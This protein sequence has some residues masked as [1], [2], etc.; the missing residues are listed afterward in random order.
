MARPP[1]SSRD[2]RNQ[3]PVAVTLSER[4]RESAL[5]NPAAIAL[6]EVSGVAISYRA[7]QKRIDD[8]TGELSALGI[9]ENDRVGLQ[10]PKSADAVAAIFALW[11]L[12]A[13]Y[14]PI[15]A[16]APAARALYAL[17]NCNTRAVIGSSKGNDRLR[18]ADAGLGPGQ[19]V[20]TQ[21]LII[22]FFDPVPGI[23]PEKHYPENLACILYTSGSTGYP[24]GVMLT[25]SNLASFVDWAISRFTL[26]PGEV[27]SSLAPLHFDLSVFD[28]FAGLGSGATVALFS[29]AVGRNPQLLADKLAG[30]RVTGVY[31]TPTL[32]QL[33]LRY[34]KLTALDYA[35][36]VRLLYAGEPFPPTALNELRRLWPDA[37][38]FNLYGPTETNVVTAYRVERGFS[39]NAIPIGTDCPYAET[40]LFSAGFL[41]HEP[42]AE[43]ELW[44]SGPS[45]AAGYVGEDTGNAFVES[46]G[47]RWYKTGD[48]VRVDEQ[49]NYVFLGRSD[50][51]I[52]RNGYRIEPAE[53]E[54][55]LS[56]HPAVAAAAVINIWGKKGRSKLLACY[57]VCPGKPTPEPAQ[58]RAYCMAKLPASFLPDGFR[59]VKEL[60]LTASHKVDYSALRRTFSS[61]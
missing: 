16:D 49:G 46:E 14:V 58:L 21:A 26:V 38:V 50:R 27:L 59:T 23:Q 36:P 53:I 42:G 30:Y 15:D 29:A 31:A 52:K 44:V 22:A 33:L 13:A 41:A 55:C 61:V 3:P 48:L 40:R 10:L 32:L 35:G 43:G 47:R 8:L 54:T 57:T 60:P 9:S 25:H 12:G 7:L 34:G 17:R 45:V 18:S 24:K 4:F 6:L 5:N 37:E 19:Q 56:G 28:I 11:A 1:V 51:M 39:G 2:E 20:G